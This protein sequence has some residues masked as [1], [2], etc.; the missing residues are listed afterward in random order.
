M[1]YK[2][3]F[4]EKVIRH[5]RLWGTTPRYLF[6]IVSSAWVIEGASGRCQW[7]SWPGRA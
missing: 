5:S 6:F 7:L 3:L 4:T 2:L 1:G